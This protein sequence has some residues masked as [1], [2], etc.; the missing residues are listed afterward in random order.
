[1]DTPNISLNGNFE[2]NLGR[3]FE[4][5]D[6]IKRMYGDEI[7]FDQ[8][9]MEL[10]LPPSIMG[11][12]RAARTYCVHTNTYHLLRVPFKTCAPPP[13]VEFASYAPAYNTISYGA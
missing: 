3:E 4:F 7:D 1:L 13:Q 2:I 6:D 8:I 11:G 12:E 9:T 10:K 5:N